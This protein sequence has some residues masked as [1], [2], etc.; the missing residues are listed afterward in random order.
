MEAG[1]CGKRADTQV[2]PYAPYS[3]EV[4]VGI[5]PTEVLRLRFPLKYAI[6]NTGPPDFR[7]EPKKQ[8]TGGPP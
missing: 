5:L 1:I 3:L 8:E 4:R 7:P 2:R 6:L